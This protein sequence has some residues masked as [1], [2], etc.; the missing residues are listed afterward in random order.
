M[1]TPEL[2]QSLTSLI[3]LARQRPT[4]I[5]CAEAVPWRC[6]RS[7]IADALAARGLRV[8]HV[9][10][11]RHATEHVLTPWARLDGAHIRY[12]APDGTPELI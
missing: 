6:H 7:L 12:A 11:P 8:T 1:E 5:T 9:L 4:A 10:G 2:E 3:R